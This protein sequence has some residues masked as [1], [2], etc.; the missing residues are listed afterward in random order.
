MS[1]TSGNGKSHS[2]KPERPRKPCCSFCRRSLGAHL[3]LVKGPG[4][5]FICGACLEQGQELLG[6]KKVEDDWEPWEKELLGELN[7]LLRGASRRRLTLE[8]ARRALRHSLRIESGK[9]VRLDR[10]SLVVEEARTQQVLEQPVNVPA[11]IDALE[12]VIQYARRLEEQMGLEELRE[13]SNGQG[14]NH[15][16]VK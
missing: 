16:G 2:G 5:V 7:R 12:D 9:D 6:P 15:Q 3:R 8:M 13:V 14:Q 11:L 4:G 10:K 1:S